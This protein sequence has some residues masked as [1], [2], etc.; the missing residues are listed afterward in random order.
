MRLISACIVVFISIISCSKDPTSTGSKQIPGSDLISAKVLDSDV[1][2]I[3]QSSSYYSFTLKAGSSGQIIL[4]KK[5]YGE[6]DVLMK[7]DVTIT[8]SS[9]AN[10]LVGNAYK[11]NSAWVTMDSTYSL[12]SQNAAFDF[13][14]YSITQYNGGLYWDLGFDRD[15]VS[16]LTYD[17]T[18]QIINSTPP[19]IDSTVMRFDLNPNLVRLWLNQQYQINNTTSK[20]LGIILKPKQGTN[21]FYGFDAITTPP[22]LH[23]EFLKPSSVLDTVVVPTYYALHYFTPAPK[24]VTRP[25]EFYLEAGQSLRGTVFFNLPDSLKL[26]LFN[27]ATLSLTVDTLNTFDGSISSSVINVQILADSAAKKLADSVTVLT[28][29]RTGNQ[30]TGDINS[31]VQKWI[32]GKVA[33]QG[34]LLSLGDETTSAARI[35]I[36]NSINLNKDLRPRLK[37]YYIKKTN[38]R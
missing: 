3:N 18:N 38:T 9:I 6:S 21:K 37:L 11:I 26:S 4:G 30:F 24:I 10:H 15:S 17:N 25:D 5:N 23:I 35:A 16:L 36:Y 27:K 29:I 2:N 32:D 13:S 28:L 8:D 1:S 33:N 22:Q 12:G 31:F 20:N 7:F 19:V 34:L 14:A